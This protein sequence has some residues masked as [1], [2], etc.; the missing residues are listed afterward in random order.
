MDKLI[1]DAQQVFGKGVVENLVSKGLDWLE[2][3]REGSVV[4]DSNGKELIDCYCSSGT[5]NLGRKNP[6]IARALKQAIHETDQ[7]ILSAASQAILPILQPFDEDCHRGL[8]DKLHTSPGSVAILPLRRGERLL[9]MLNLASNDPDR[10][11]PE[12]ATDFLQH[13]AAIAA[14]CLEN[15]INHERLRHLGL[16][17]AFRAMNA[18]GG[19]YSWWDYRAGAWDRDQGCRID[20][21]FLSPQAT[22]RLAASGIDRTPRGWEKPSDHTPVW[23]ELSL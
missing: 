21:L 12:R 11:T 5:Y 2:S 17:D 1:A 6:A 4:Y 9:G 7:G 3:G 13:L 19:R 16:T 15:A 22:D 20:H 14:V 18:E 8:F 10:F 23:C